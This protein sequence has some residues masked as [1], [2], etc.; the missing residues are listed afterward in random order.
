[1]TWPAE[2]TRSAT[3]AAVRVN[4]GTPLPLT[5][6]EKTTGRVEVES[7]PDVKVELIAYNWLRDSRGI[8]HYLKPVANTAP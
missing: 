8:V 4:D 5:P 1:V 2:Q 6:E 3:Y 7:R